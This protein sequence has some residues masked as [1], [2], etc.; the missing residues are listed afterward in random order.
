MTCQRQHIYDIYEWEES[1]HYLHLVPAA[2]FMWRFRE[3]GKGILKPFKME[4]ILIHKYGTIQDPD[5]MDRGR[6]RFPEL[7]T[8]VRT[9]L[10]RT[11][12][13]PP[14]PDDP[15]GI[16]DE[17]KRRRLGKR[18]MGPPC[19]PGVPENQ[20]FERDLDWER[21][22]P[23]KDDPVYPEEVPKP[24]KKG[25]QPAENS[26]NKRLRLYSSDGQFKQ[27]KRPRQASRSGQGNQPRQ[28][29]G[30]NGDQ[31][32]ANT[33]TRQDNMEREENE[34]EGHGSYSGNYRGKPGGWKRGRPFMRA[35][36]GGRRGR[37]GFPRW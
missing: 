3:P 11:P 26:T 22:L 1:L 33:S 17:N 14:R 8:A 30:A 19:R 15:D 5:M 13:P 21:I 23:D 7:C 9:S 27:S 18:P 29:S 12:S 16:R 32:M 31:D 28:S 37:R 4:D 6:I 36:G 20:S 10:T 35:R 2:P 34:E 25:K 24:S